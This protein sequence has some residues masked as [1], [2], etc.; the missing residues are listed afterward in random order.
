MLSATFTLEASRV[1]DALMI[2]VVE[3]GQEPKPV[4]KVP[5][6]LID[7]G[8]EDAFWA[9]VCGARPDWF[10]EAT[11]NLEVELVGF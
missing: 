3:E 6:W 1:G 8:T 9:G 2:Y 11:R 5:W 4:R 7:G 10:N